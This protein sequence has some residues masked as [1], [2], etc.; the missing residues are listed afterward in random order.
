[1]ISVSPPSTEYIILNAGTGRDGRSSHQDT[2]TTNSRKTTKYK[3]NT[4]V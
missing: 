1:L 4:T 3:W 2:A